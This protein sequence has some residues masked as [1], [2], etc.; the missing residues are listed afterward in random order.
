MGD[1]AQALE[2]IRVDVL[3]RRPAVPVALA[4]IPGIAVHE[5]LWHRPLLWLAA[6]AVTFLSAM[7]IAFW[8]RS[9]WRPLFFAP[10]I[11]FCGV[12]SAQFFHFSYPPEH[13]GS[14]ATFAPTPTEL[15]LH[16][17]TP[18][19]IADSGAPFHPI[20]PRQLASATVT[21]VNMAG[22]WQPACGQLNLYIDQ[23]HPR[24][25]QGQKLRVT[26]LLERPLPALNPGQFDY[27]QH[28]AQQRVL[29]SLIVKKS[30]DIEILTD[31]SPSLLDRYRSA[32]ADALANGFP[33]ERHLDQATL[34]MLVLGQN[35][36]DARSVRDDFTRTG[37][38]YELAVSGLH[39]ALV[40]MLILFFS[41][42]FCLNPRLRTALTMLIVVLYAFAARP[43]PPVLRASFLCAAF[44]S[45]CLLKR[46]PDKLQLLALA[47]I[48]DLVFRPLDL[49]TAGFQLSF[50]NVLAFILFWPTIM[51]ISHGSSYT[52]MRI[53]L[54]FSH[55]SPARRIWMTIRHWLV[56][57]LAFN[58]I[59][60]LASAPLIAYHF[61]QVNPY[62]ILFGPAMLPLVA[63]SLFSGILKILLTLLLPGF[64]TAWAAF[65][66]MPTEWMRHTVALLV[67]IPGAS[68]PTPPISASFVFGYYAVLSLPLL[69]NLFGRLARRLTLRPAMACLL[70]FLPL[71]VG[72][73]SH[74]PQRED[75]TLTLLSIGAG[76]TAV[77]DL[78]SGQ[79]VLVDDGSATLVDPVQS[80]LN[81]FLR[82]EYCRGI[83]AIFLS[84]PDFD[85]VSGTLE[86]EKNWHAD[87]VYVNSA[88]IGESEKMPHA[89]Y[90]LEQ[91]AGD[92]CPV[93]PLKRGDT[94]NLDDSTKLEVLWPPEGRSFATTNEAGLVLKITCCGRSIL[95]PSDIQQFTEHDLLASAADLKSDVL[96]APHHGSAEIT[97]FAFIHAVDPICILSSN[98][99][100]LSNKQKA[101]DAIARAADKPLYRTS[102]CG[103]VSVH[104]TP[105]G[106][107]HVETFLPPEQWLPDAEKWKH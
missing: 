61:G 76:Q 55:P 2:R 64:A 53:A 71:L 28:E 11:F 98:D 81:P 86:T 6:C 31:A 54:A 32:V 94:L 5:L 8:R 17:D 26:G 69:S 16:V 27:A 15:E 59:A 23:P 91:L 104:I 40:G 34:A 102:R 100:L 58:L 78:P 80:C 83:A 103:A 65:A 68:F 35:S 45:A 24:L 89:R 42:L 14:L 82:Q 66:A 22:G 21:A 107:I 70:V 36:P 9:L 75:F 43:A 52:D 49:F 3:V 48:A 30:S 72:A 37:T 62:T 85:H 60:C 20:P 50:I 44:A 41:R 13:V 7:A 39:V 29:A 1:L 88:F 12:V 97:T 63:A 79:V 19:R 99:R 84:H 25:A 90:L 77:I 87:T 18:P 57:S 92:H 38:A 101:F 51:A 93:H 73:T 47:A 56:A 67:K 74:R 95:F 4:F 46:R 105:S 96:I 10:P 106:Q 33:P